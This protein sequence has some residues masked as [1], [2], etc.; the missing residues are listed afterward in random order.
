MN[1]IEEYINR[2][3]E[4][5]LARNKRQKQFWDMITY[6]VMIGI[7]S[8][9]ALTILPMIGSEL[10]LSLLLPSTFAGWLV[11]ICSKLLVAGV[12]ML[13]F[14]C[15]MEQGRTNVKNHW[16][17][18]IA[19]ELLHRLRKLANIPRSP[20]IWKKGE[21]QFKG[22]TICI[23]TLLSAF[24]L[25]HAVLSFDWPA[26]LS[27]FLTIIMGLVFGLLQMKKSECYWAEEYYDYALYETDI[28]NK[29]AELK[30]TVD[31][32]NYR[33]LEGDKVIY[34]YNRQYSIS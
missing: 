8:I 14:Y 29:T 22:S 31:E 1:R 3:P 21:Y 25:G 2:T 16:H 33:I 4:E 19:N 9:L 24:V 27:Y 23:S 30:L 26:F 32:Q 5:T 20:E 28:Y 15:F 34:D 12:N 13:L 17:H 18:V 10:P 7:V 6:Y 11:Y